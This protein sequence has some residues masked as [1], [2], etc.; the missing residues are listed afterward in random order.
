MTVGEFV[1]QVFI[2]VEGGQ[3]TQDTNIFREDIRNYLPSLANY[4]IT[5][6]YF[7]NKQDGESIVPSDFIATYEDVEV[8]YDD[9]RGKSY[10][11]LPVPLVTL[12]KDMGLQ[13]VSPMKGT[14]TFARLPIQAEQHM[15]TVYQNVPDTVWYMLEGA[16]VFLINIPKEV[17]TLL[18]RTVVNIHTLSDND[19]FPIPSGDVVAALDKCVE[20]FL[21]QKGIMPDQGNDN[22]EAIR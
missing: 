3:L 16:K 2:L 10:I 14:Y 11:E 9:R 6:Q 7:I 19:Y 22:R 17:E 12:P 4:F 5:K 13:M 20:F 8:L 18:V 1:E 15:A 21:K